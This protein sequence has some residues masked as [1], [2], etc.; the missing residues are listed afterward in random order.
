MVATTWQA[1]ATTRLM[2]IT[3]PSPV[4]DGWGCPMNAVPVMTARANSRATRA[5]R[6]S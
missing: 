6:P 2:R 3:S 1:T 4:Q 5:K